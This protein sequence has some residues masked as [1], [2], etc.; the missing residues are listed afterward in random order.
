M[1]ILVDENVPIQILELARLYLVGHQVDH[2]DNL[3]WK[4]K[5]DR[6]VFRDAQTRGYNAILTNDQNQ[7]ADPEELK[8]LR[9]AKL[10]HVLYPNP[11]RG[12]GTAG[13]ARVLGSVLATLPAIVVFLERAEEPQ[14]ISVSV[15]DGRSFTPVANRSLV[16]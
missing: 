4:R 1:K 3:R 7:L 11:P 10:H 16:R 2:V 5:K 9:Q 14:V 15:S 6:A 13:Q 12:S 8:A